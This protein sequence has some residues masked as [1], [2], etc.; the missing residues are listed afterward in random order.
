M[1]TDPPVS[2]ITSVQKINEG[3]K[4]FYCISPNKS[5]RSYA[6]RAWGAFILHPIC[7]AKNSS[8]FVFFC[9]Q[10]IFRM[11]CLSNWRKYSSNSSKIVILINLCS[12]RYH[13]LKTFLEKELLLGKVLLLR[14]IRY[15]KKGFTSIYTC[16][17]E[18][19]FQLFAKWQN[20]YWKQLQMKN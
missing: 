4:Y 2:E 13:D 12:S 18:E 7:N 20:L 17:E 1:K 14:E 19:G 15:I 10:E 11:N 16:L 5:S 3:I 8:S 9:V 6:K